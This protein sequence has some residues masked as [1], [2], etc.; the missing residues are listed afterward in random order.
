MRRR[1]P[2]RQSTLRRDLIIGCLLGLILCLP[3]V[4]V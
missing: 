4:T 2:H 1:T 3:V